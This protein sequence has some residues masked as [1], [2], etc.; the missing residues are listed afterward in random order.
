MLHG[1]CFTFSRKEPP[2]P[3]EAPCTWEY[4]AGYRV[5]QIS[6]I[7]NRSIGCMRRMLVAG[8]S[9]LAFWVILESP[10]N[11]GK[12]FIDNCFWDFLPLFKAGII[13]LNPV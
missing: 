1:A 8:G 12:A 13:Q 4:R 5:K 7:N 6:N 3:P 2:W 10:V 11:C 9:M